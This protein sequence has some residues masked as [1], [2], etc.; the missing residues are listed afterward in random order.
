M[1]L[2]S[3]VERRRLT[4]YFRLRLPVGIDDLLGRT[5]LIASLGTRDPG[6]AKIRAARLFFVVAGFLKTMSLRMRDREHIDGNEDYTAASLAAAAFELGCHYRADVDALRQHYR[7]ALRDMIDRAQNEWKGGAQAGKQSID[8]VSNLKFPSSIELGLS[9]SASV[10]A[11]TGRLAGMGSG[12]DNSFGPSGVGGRESQAITAAVGTSTSGSPWHSHLNSFL[13]DKPGLTSKTRWSYDQAFAAWRSL[14]GDKP[15]DAIRRPDLK[16]YADYLRDRPNPRG[17]QLNHQTIVRSLG[18]LKTFMAW[19]VAAGLT[20]DDRFES[21]QA[22]STT[23]AEKLA[24]PPRRA[25]TEA[26][27]VKLFHSKWFVRP[28]DRDERAA[29]WFL[30]VAALTG[31][32][33]EELTNAPAHFVRIGDID[34]LDLRLVGRKTSAA[35]RL[36]PLL[37]DLL[38]MGLAEWA[39]DQDAH[40]FPLFQPGAVPLSAAAWSKRLNRYI[41]RTISND[42]TLVLYSLRHSFRQMLRAAAIGEEL[43]DKVFG[44]SS[45]RVGAGYGRAL[46]AQEAALFIDRVH[47]PVGLHHLWKIVS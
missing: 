36:V 4:Y 44:H 24:G 1:A 22:R 2:C 13:A 3:Y 42:P 12:P 28:Q 19:A 23:S 20:D 21:V 25:F 26:E 6:A 40:G 29:A 39:A 30:A 14:I 8:F 37:P 41:S 16:L 18:H 5:H 11:G 46:S 45:D 47:P 38:R 27:L 35:P 17:G 7:A 33:T 31:A 15:I 34:C 10:C 32:R 43:A 9:P